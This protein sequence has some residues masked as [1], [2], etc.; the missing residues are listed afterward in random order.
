MNYRKYLGGDLRTA[1]GFVGIMALATLMGGHPDSVGQWLLMTAAFVALFV[2]WPVVV[3][4]VWAVLFPAAFLLEWILSVV[5]K[6][7]SWFVFGLF[8]RK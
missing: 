2:A 3:W 1:G 4:M 5:G 6:G 7:I 8:N